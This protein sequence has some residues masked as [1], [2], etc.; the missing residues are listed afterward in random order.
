MALLVEDWVSRASAKQR[1][2]RAGR[3]RPGK[4]FSLFTRRRMEEDLRPFQVWK[5]QGIQTN[6][7]L[8][9]SH[10]TRSY[11]IPP[12]A[13][14]SIPLNELNG[15]GPR[16]QACPLGGPSATDPCHGASAGCHIPQ[17]GSGAAGG[18]SHQGGGGNA[19]G[20]TCADN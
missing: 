16:D 12:E 15:V 4:C 14:S 20:G 6:R 17:H 5:G 8:L 19:A 10:L 9:S 3:V 13:L 18:G 2:G 1:R 11:E 7:P